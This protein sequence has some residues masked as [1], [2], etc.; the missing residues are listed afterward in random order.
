MLAG[1]NGGDAAEGVVALTTGALNPPAGVACEEKC[2]SDM[3]P[4]PPPASL[5]TLIILEVS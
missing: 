2:G 3:H 5:P 1:L 4:S